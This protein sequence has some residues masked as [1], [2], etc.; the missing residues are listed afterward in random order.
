MT[1]TY[2]IAQCVAP[3]ERCRLSHDMNSCQ[4][5]LSHEL[6]LVRV[7]TARTKK[8]TSI[9]RTNSCPL[10]IAATLSFASFPARLF[11]QFSCVASGYLASTNLR[12][13]LGQLHLV[14]VADASEFD[15]C[16]PDY[17]PGKYPTKRRADRVLVQ[18]FMACNG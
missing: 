17:A 14:C 9:V 11:M 15:C 12:Q 4:I 10:L 8:R 6:R 3:N 2:C 13:R 16:L 7:L 5:T 1:T 18:Q